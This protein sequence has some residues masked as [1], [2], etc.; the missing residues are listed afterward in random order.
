MCES[1]KRSNPQISA[2]AHRL[3]VQSYN[4]IYEKRPPLS[5]PSVVLV[6]PRTKRRRKIHPCSPVSAKRNE[7]TTEWKHTAHTHPRGGAHIETHYD[8]SGFKILATPRHD[9]PSGEQAC[10]VR[11]KPRKG[12]RF[13]G[14]EV[15]GHADGRGQEVHRTVG[16]GDLTRHAA[17]GPGGDWAEGSRGVEARRL[18]LRFETPDSLVWPPLWP[19][20]SP[21][22]KQWRWEL[23]AG[24]QPSRGGLVSGAP[25]IRWRAT[26]LQNQKHRC[27][28]GKVGRGCHVIRVAL[29][30]FLFYNLFSLFAS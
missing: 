11:R 15:E 24:E 9:I 12:H 7:R 14:E 2:S 17:R 30:P 8:T 27:Q 28:T 21:R 19:P 25:E 18:G 1:L 22:L 20:I 26:S 3:Q 4:W 23:G 10:A 6:R 13:R 5:A 29:Y 16:G